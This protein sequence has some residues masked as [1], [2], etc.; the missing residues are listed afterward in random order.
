MPNITNKVSLYGDSVT[1]AADYPSRMMSRA[2]GK[3]AGIV[4]YARGGNTFAANLSGRLFD[5]PL[6]NGLDFATHIAKVDDAD[7][8]VIRLG[9]NSVPAGWD[10]DDSQA[11]LGADYLD[12]CAEIFLHVQYVRA[13]GKRLVLV[14]TPYTNIASYMSYWGLPEGRAVTDLQRIR[15]A[16]SGIRY[17]CA[18]LGVP[19]IATHGQ[20]GDGRHPPAGAADVPD[21]VHPSPQYHDAVGDYLAGAIVRALK[22]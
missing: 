1:A 7:I 9:G 2:P 18:T 12:I 5:L 10:K 4:S 3:F 11:C 17:V 16:N 22:L 21:G 15:H 6:F 8:V 19:F 14:G 20:G 13:A